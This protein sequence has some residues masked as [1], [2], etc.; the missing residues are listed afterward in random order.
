MLAKNKKLLILTSLLTLLPIPVGL[1]LWSKF[2]ETMAIHFGITGDADG[3]A[4]PS[5]IVFVLPLIMLG[6]HWLC[7]FFT[8]LDNGNRNRNQKMFRI[9]L[10]SVPLIGN[11]SILGI[12]A[13]SLGLEFSPVA[14]TMI[15]MG[16]LFA[17]MGNYMPK[18]RTNSTMGIK[19]YWTYT[20]E[21]NWNATHR[22]AGKVWFL[23]GLM[24]LFAALIPAKYVLWFFLAAAAVIVF[25]PILYSWQYYRKQLRQ[26]D[27][28]LYPHRDKK[29]TRSSQIALAVV[30][31]LVAVLMFT[32]SID[33]V[34][35]EESFT[36]EATFHD[37]L[38]VDYD[39][40]DSIEYREGNVE[41]YRVMGYASARLLLGVFE[42]EEFGHYTR[43][44]Y[45]HPGGCIVLTAGDQVLVFCGK[46]AQDTQTIYNYLTAKIS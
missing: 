20:S 23:G 33:I 12:Y 4:R 37:N 42:N 27:E 19:V 45:T 46:D 30:L 40:I 26:G 44:T 3:F 11:L 39:A 6:V 18:T 35:G 29:A 22:M 36:I 10:W 1:A 9:V 25:V 17:V 41:G 2:P 34:L 24:M 38:T 15:P 5:V 16:L 7:A 21:E 8:S 43:Y 32:G 13:F 31:I 28:L 14:W